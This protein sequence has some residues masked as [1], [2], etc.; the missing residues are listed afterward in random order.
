MKFK[1]FTRVVICLLLITHPEIATSQ[2]QSFLQV[3]VNSN[4]DRAIAPDDI[5]T[6]REAIAIMN[7]TLPLDQLSPREKALVKNHTQPQIAFNLPPGR[8]TIT[9]QQLL[10]PLTTPGLV[11]DGTTQP[12]Y[13]SAKSLTTAISIPQPIVSITP[14]PGVEVFRGLTVVAN[15]VTIRGLSLYGFTSQHRATETT[16]PADIFIT[17]SDSNLPSDRVLIEN[18]WLGITPNA[19]I[20]STTSA[21]GVSVFN[22]TNTVIRRNRI[23]HHDGSGIITGNQATGTQVTENMIL[24]NGIRGMPDAIRL[25]GIINQSAVSA[26]LI[27][28]NDGS[29]VFLFKPEGSVKILDNQIKFN[30]RRLRRA[31]IFVMGSNHQIQNNQISA[32]NGPGVVVSAFP[33]GGSFHHGAA[34]GNL[35]QNNRFSNLQ[36]LSIDL[37]TRAHLGVEDFQ[38]GD[39]K[40]PRRDTENRRWDTANAAIN[41]PEFLAPEFLLINHQVHLDGIADP[42]TEIEIYRV[43]LDG[44]LAE[45]LTT[46]KADDSGRFGAT[47]RNLQPGSRV[48]AIATDA[49]YGTSEPAN[50]AVI[51]TKIGEKLTPPPPP[52][53]DIPSCG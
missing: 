52:T 1:A 33:P 49:K 2:T 27:C 18:N 50:H 4:Q 36:G 11:V 48:S 29:G 3:T 42:G 26:N 31:A 15:Q 9:L 34:M 14:A 38:R 39:G 5:L 46:L 51:V 22:A 8:T 43:G 10:P 40:N 41:A 7:G 45:V 21:F 6:L 53:V 25:D 17:S 24:G 35:I 19:D 28:A 12:G 16:P 20:P 37:N 47:L 13:D 30:G 23:S 44:A 32:Q